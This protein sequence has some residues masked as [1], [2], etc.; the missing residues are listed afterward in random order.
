M[1]E[2]T[3]ASYAGHVE[4]HLVPR[5]GHL[6]LRDLR[7]HHVEQAYRDILAQRAERPVGASGLRRVHATVMSALNA[8]VRR[9]LIR[10]NPAAGVELPRPV[11][12]E[13]TVWS[14]AEATRFLQAIRDDRWYLIYRL[15]LI[16]G[17]R[18]GEALG[19]RWDDLD[20]DAHT[21]TVRRQ[22]TVVRGRLIDTTP[23]SRAGVRTIA[24]DEI[25]MAGLRA[26]RRERPTPIAG[27]SGGVFVTD[28]GDP[29]HPAAVS[30]HFSVLVRRAGLP[31]I[32]LHDLR[33]T[34]ATLG[35]AGGE[36]LLEVS[37]RLGH[38]SITVT[39][40][41]YAHPTGDQARTAV[42]RLAAQLHP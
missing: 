28:T 37:R 23:K 30:R 14:V 38:S 33:H 16:G 25:T 11:E 22:L 31:M 12:T 10:R 29:I 39:A 35:L 1:K 13:R 36:T 32:R 40:D 24:L 7:A 2:S 6:K 15:L 27:A 21:L 4:Q 41:I 34:S 9:G 20:W 8:A 3:R 19:V 5:L 42:T 17:L 26:L 18:R